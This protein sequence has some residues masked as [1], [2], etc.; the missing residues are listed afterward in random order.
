[1][2]ESNLIMALDESVRGLPQVEIEADTADIFEIRPS[3]IRSLG[4]GE[5]N[6]LLSEIDYFT[7]RL[8]DAKMRRAKM[9]SVVVVKGSNINVH[10]DSALGFLREIR[11]TILS[12]MS[13]K[14]A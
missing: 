9:V 10:V 12:E 8:A 2:S 7:P 14:C 4:C 6:H 3:D 1:M 11:Q 5:L 13:R